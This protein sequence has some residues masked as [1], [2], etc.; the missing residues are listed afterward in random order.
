MDVITQFFIKL[1]DLLQPYLFKTCMAQ[2]ATVLV[3]YSRDIDRYLRTLLKPHP[4]IVR[5]SLFVLVN[6]FGYGFVA[7]SGGGLMAQ[8]YQQIGSPVRVPVILTVFLAIGILA[9]RRKHI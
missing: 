9:E 2:V 6:A 4:F 3:I 7:I 8:F 1:A 5:V